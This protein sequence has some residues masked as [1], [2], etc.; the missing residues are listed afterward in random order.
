MEI[1][2]ILLLIVLNGV[3]SMSEIAVVSSRKT[4]LEQDAKEDRPGATAALQL[5]WCPST[6]LCTTSA[7]PARPKRK[8]TVFTPWAGF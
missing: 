4:R 2:V 8:E 1:V 7:C 3:F 5:R 6:S